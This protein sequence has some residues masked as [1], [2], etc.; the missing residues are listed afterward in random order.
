MENGFYI[1]A[2]YLA[3][4]AVECMLKALILNASPKRQHAS[5]EAGFRGKR[6][7][8]FE[9]LR[10]QCKRL[11]SIAFPPTVSQS[12]AFVGTWETDL[13]YRPGLGSLQDAQ[14]F[15]EVTKSI[16]SW[17]DDHL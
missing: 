12:L 16:V 3:G 5:L 7:H 6:A 13:R 10:L 4:Y 1:G 8:D 17:A 11:G 2:V 14:R 9:E 15:L